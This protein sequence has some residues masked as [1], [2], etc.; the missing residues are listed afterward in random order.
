MSGPPT[1]I[2]YFFFFFF[3]VAETAKLGHGISYFL[4]SLGLDLW[5]S[6][7]NNIFFVDVVVVI[8]TDMIKK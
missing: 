1:Y 8:V 5:I 6:L 7:I 2:C 3:S 4:F